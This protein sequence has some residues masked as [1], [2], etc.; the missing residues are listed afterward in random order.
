[1]PLTPCQQITHVLLKLGILPFPAKATAC[2]PCNVPVAPTLQ[3][4]CQDPLS[5]P[6]KVGRCGKTS[7]CGDLSW[8]MPGAPRVS[9]LLGDHNAPQRK[10]L[11]DNV[12][13]WLSTGSMDDM[14][15]LGSLGRLDCNALFANLKIWF[16]LSFATSPWRPSAAPILCN[17]QQHFFLLFAHRRGRWSVVKDEKAPH[18]PLGLLLD[19]PVVHLGPRKL[20]LPTCRV[21][22]TTLHYSAQVHCQMGSEIQCHHP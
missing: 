20:V 21:R 17:D 3:H 18:P 13:A 1:M 8:R 12:C 6:C 14:G 2:P 10:A 19:K 5:V 16:L 4:S 7:L 11:E 9:G 15:F 22:Q